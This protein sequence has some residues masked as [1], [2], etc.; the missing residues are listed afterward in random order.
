M[1]KRQFAL[2]LILA[3][4]FGVVL[5]SGCV[6]PQIGYCGNGVCDGNETSLTCPADCG[7]TPG[8]SGGGNGGVITPA[9]G[10]RTTTAGTGALIGV[11]SGLN[12]KY[13]VGDA[14]APKA[15]VD[16]SALKGAASA[17]SLNASVSFSQITDGVVRGEYRDRDGN[18][19]Y[20]VD[21]YSKAMPGENSSSDLPVGLAAYYP[22]DNNFLDES[23]NGNDANIYGGGGFF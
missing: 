22:F 6:A 14:V 3:S 16:S 17:S 12:F 15:G 18:V 9:K 21:W 1:H 7:L 23:G 5:F 11:E 10:E 20:N 19:W 8:G 4:V 13:G 2:A